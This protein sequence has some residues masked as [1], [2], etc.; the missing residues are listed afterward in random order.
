MNMKDWSKGHVHCTLC[1]IKNF[2]TIDKEITGD[3]KPRLMRPTVDSECPLLRVARP[4]YTAT[5]ELGNHI[6]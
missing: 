6:G 3:I 4:M 2:C 5:D 1:P